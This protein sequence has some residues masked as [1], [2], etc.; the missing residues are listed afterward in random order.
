[1]AWIRQ[2]P[3]SA[4]KFSSNQIWLAVALVVG[5]GAAWLPL[6]VVVVAV[7]GTAVFVLTFI[8]PLVGLGLAL[9]AGPWGALESFIWGSSVIDSGQLLLLFTLAVW[10]GRGLSRRRLV[11]PQTPLNWPLFV[12]VGVGTL[13]L[14]NAPSLTF[15]LKEA[16]K[17]LEMGLIMWLVVD[18][19]R[20]SGRRAVAGVLFMLLLAGLGQAMVGI[21][22]FGLRGDGPAHFAILGGLVPPSGYFWYTFPTS[23]TVAYW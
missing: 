20:E 22:Q 10:L 9:L 16:V 21:W 12:L 6:P 4:T 8:Q 11:L 2:W 3:F 1:M 19:G 7:G 17:W 13:T 14:L 5:L 18:V 23:H 15:G